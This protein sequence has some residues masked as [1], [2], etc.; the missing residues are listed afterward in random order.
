MSNKLTPERLRRMLRGKSVTNKQ[1]KFFNNSLSKYLRAENG[2]EATMGGLTDKGFNYNGAWGGPSMAMGGGIPG[3]VGFTYARTQDPAPS[4]GPYAKKTKPS[5]QNGQEMKYYQE[6]LDFKPK[7]IS[8]NG[9]W[10]EKFEE[11]GIIEDDMGQWAHPGEITKINSNQITM[12]GVDYPVLGIS[13]TGDTQMMYPGEDYSFEGSSVT[14]IPMAQR[15]RVVPLKELIGK[16]DEKLKAKSDATKVVPQ[17]TMTVEQAKK[18]KA[19]READELARRKQAIETSYAARKKPFSAQ[20]LA[21]ETGAIGD[22]LRIFPE[23]PDSFIDEYLNPGVMIGNLA[24]GL[25]RIPLDISQG[26][27]GRA[28]TSVALPLGVGALAGIG[29]KGTGQFVSN[30]I[31]PLA[32][33]GDLTAGARAFLSDKASESGKGFLSRLRE[34]SP[35]YEDP[36]VTAVRKFH[37]EELNRM[38]NTPEGLRRLEATGIDPKILKKNKP[39]LTL[40]DRVKNFYQSEYDWDSKPRINISESDLERGIA[41]GIIPENFP[42]SAIHSHEF[43]HYLQDMYLR[44]NPELLQPYIERYNLQKKAYEEYQ[45]LSDAEKLVNR[46][47]PTKPN[48]RLL[49]PLTLPINIDETARELKGIGLSPDDYFAKRSRSYFEG[50]YDANLTGDKVD[51]ERLPIIRESRQQMLNQGYISDIYETPSLET[52]KKFIEENRQTDRLASFL[53]TSPKNLKRLQD[54]YKILPAA[55]PIAIASSQSSDKKKNGGWL[56]KYE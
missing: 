19:R 5:A 36:E 16:E 10:L 43:G 38:L 52:L 51:I 28:A 27:Y 15:G 42:A 46:N 41:Y 4:N 32:G 6:G 8:E 24:S 2:A 35:F 30:I 49:N 12:Q 48:E 44:S 23:D 21:E 47:A 9:G 34:W 31:N 25:G 40:S 22:K 13:D 33:T 20:Q 39:K 26:N 45:K 37:K 18:L 11:G 53:D 14:E 55:A 29:A 3:A 1:R 7:T 50:S 56:N 17:K 54:I